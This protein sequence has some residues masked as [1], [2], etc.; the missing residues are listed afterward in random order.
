MQPS[1]SKP[2]PDQSKLSDATISKALRVLAPRKIAR[3]LYDSNQ[4]FYILDGKDRIRYVNKALLEVLKVEEIRLIGLE[5]GQTCNHDVDQNRLA[6]LLSI[7]AAARLSTAA[8]IP[9]KVSSENGPGWTAKLLISM[10]SNFGNGSVGCWLLTDSDSI[11]QQAGTRASWLNSQEI[12][13]AITHARQAFPK[14]DGMYSLIGLSPSASLA[15]KQAKAAIEG[16][17]PFCITGPTGCGKSTL[18]QS[19]L[20]LQSKRRRRNLASQP[21]LP[22]ECRLM[23]RG[24]MQEMLELAQERALPTEKLDD[25]TEMPSLLLKNLDQL[26]TESH[27]LLVNF[28][29]RNGSSVVVATANT[30]DLWSLYPNCKDWQSILAMVDVM[31]IR[32]LP[33]H[34]RIEDISPT[35]IAILDDLQLSLP[36]TSRK[37]LSKQSLACLE[38]YAW[39]N[40]LRE[41]IHTLREALTKS[42]QASIEPSDFSLALQTFASFVL[43]PEPIKGVQ[44]DQVMEDVERQLIQQA[45]A[46]HPRNRAEVARQL[47]I[48]RARLLR[49]LS[50]L[51]LEE[52]PEKNE[53]SQLRAANQV[54]VSTKRTETKKPP[55]VATDKPGT[56]SDDSTPI[57]SNAE[58]P[59]F[60]ELHEDNLKHE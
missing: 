2:T 13:S 50:E 17:M 55:V 9:F 3:L 57:E 33:L 7:P 27:P 56:I 54:T 5:C 48:S 16:S 45:L 43:K 53:P 29:R 25:S 28:I 12:Q 37:H 38:G 59:I 8:I 42:A 32:L 35:A 46:A 41:L 31:S 11:V 49:R 30:E 24:L 26:P 47:G 21:I 40:D 52:S 4:P 14:L 23:D 19:M 60:V 10:D 6:S 34:R 15:R 22:I 1:D 51:H 20:Q 39:P 18:A 58:T 44:L 36:A